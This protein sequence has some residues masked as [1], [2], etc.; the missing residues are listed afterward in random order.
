[1]QLFQNTQR[2][3]FSWTLIK[4]NSTTYFF[5]TIFQSFWCSYFKTPS[6][7]H[8]WW[9]L[10]EF[11]SLYTVVLFISKNDSTRDNS[12][13]FLEVKLSPLKSM[14]WIP[15]LVATCNICKNR[16][17]HRCCLSGYCEKYHVQSTE[18]WSSILVKT[19]NLHG[20]K[21]SMTRLALSQNQ[22]NGVWLRRFAESVLFLWQH[23]GNFFKSLFITNLQAFLVNDRESIPRNVT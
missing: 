13:K 7:N 6:L 2:K 5:L 9:S 19:W 18:L 10:V 11:W 22:K 8:L 17:I 4:G 16:V 20:K 1:M 21:D 14:W 15:I 12:L 3:H 23:K